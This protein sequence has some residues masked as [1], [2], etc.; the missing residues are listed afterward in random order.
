VLQELR[1]DEG[2]GEW[3]RPMIE[4]F[5][6]ATGKAPAGYHCSR[7]STQGVKLWRQYQTLA[8]YVQLLCAPCA[9][10]DQKRPDDVDALG[11]I[12]DST[13]GGRCDQIGWLVPAVPTEDGET[14]WGYT[15]VPQMGVDWWRQL[16]TRS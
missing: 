3:N 10:A 13:V 2:K 14:Y 1:E 5:S 8:C 11:Y 16:P 12:E 9:C 6:Y 7:C 4:A 15:S